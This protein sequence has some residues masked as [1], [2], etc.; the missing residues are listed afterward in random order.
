MVREERRE[1]TEMSFSHWFMV[2]STES[3]LRL[4]RCT[5]D[6]VMRVLVRARIMLVESFIMTL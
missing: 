4:E 2:A 3:G 1:H 5:G 6:A